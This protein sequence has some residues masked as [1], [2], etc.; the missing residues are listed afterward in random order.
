M[1]IWNLHFTRCLPE[2]TYHGPPGLSSRVAPPVLGRIGLLVASLLLT[3]APS[4]VSLRSFV[5]P[6]VGNFGVTG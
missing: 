4:A 6:K 2:F 1:K 5:N 3:V